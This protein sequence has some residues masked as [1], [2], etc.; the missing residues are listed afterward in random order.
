MK[1]RTKKRIR[2]MRAAAVATCVAGLA[3]P[4][5]A[6]AS[7]GPTPHPHGRPFA[8]PTGISADTI[9]SQSLKPGSSPAYVLPS[10]H[11]TDVQS[12]P[13]AATPAPAPATVV[14]EVRTVTNSSDHTLA[15]V[16]AAAALGIA[17]CGTGYAL[18]RIASIKR[19]ALGSNA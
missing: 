15:I 3:A 5:V 14:R 13:P 12:S 8:A 19:R 18:S 7:A 17:L 2:L 6:G 1:V 11:T 4:S 10:S 9:S 16:L